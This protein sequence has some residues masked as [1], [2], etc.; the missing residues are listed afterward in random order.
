MRY[1]KKNNNE[2][3]AYDDEQVAQGLT[4]GLEEITEKETDKILHPPLTETEA[5]TKLIENFKKVV[6]SMLDTKAQ[7][8]GYDDIVSACS[9][10][11]YENEFRAEGEAF[12]I[13]RAKCWR[14]GYD[15]LERYKD[16]LT[17]NIPS[18]D[19]MLKSMPEYVEVK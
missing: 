3:Y 4:E 17:K 1:F 14:W 6:Q 2:I 18:I 11:G 12:G 10:A 16:T 15:L 13:W 8:K 19:E 5:K 7:E 9:Y